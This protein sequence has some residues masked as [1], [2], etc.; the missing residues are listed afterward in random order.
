MSRMSDL[1]IDL[2]EEFGRIPEPEIIAAWLNFKSPVVALSLPINPKA[3]LAH[4]LCDGN[5]YDING[6]LIDD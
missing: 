5:E 4:L 2:M 1:H 6:G 3:P